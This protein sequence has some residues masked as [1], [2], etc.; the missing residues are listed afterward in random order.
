MRLPRLAMGMI[1][2]GLASAAGWFGWQFR[3]YFEKVHKPG[4]QTMTA[5][6]LIARGPDRGHAV[7]LT[8]VELGEPIV[9]D[10]GPGAAPD[11]WI[12]IYPA[13]AGRGKR[14][15]TDMPRILYHTRDS[16]SPE[17]VVDR[18]RKG[19]DLTG[20]VM[21]RLPGGELELPP[22]VLAAHPQINPAGTW[23]VRGDRVWQQGAVFWTAALAATFG[24]FG[25][26]L[27]LSGLFGTANRHWTRESRSLPGLRPLDARTSGR[28]SR[29]YYHR[30]C[31][32]NTLASGDDLVRLECP[33]RACSGTFCCGCAKVVPLAS[34]HWEDTGESVAEYRVRIASAV[35]FW[36]RWQLTWLGN[37]YQGAVNLGLDAKGRVVQPLREPPGPARTS[38]ALRA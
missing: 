3:P 24:A 26:W 36:R 6:E 21:N 20:T 32:S 34:V 13:R 2:F 25:L 38:A 1:C 31:G 12:P 7:S 5:A 15:P 10:R 27:V 9:I 18:F 23:Y 35:P 14:S 4:P 19:A 11:V 33:F 8:D 28:A 17:A 29:A 22:A 30:P 16:L 37:A